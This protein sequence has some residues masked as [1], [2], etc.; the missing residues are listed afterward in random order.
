MI[1]LVSPASLRK[2]G[3][4]GRAVPARKQGVVMDGC[5]CGGSMVSGGFY[6]GDNWQA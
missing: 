2:T 1:F 4:H 6:R 5:H 3:M